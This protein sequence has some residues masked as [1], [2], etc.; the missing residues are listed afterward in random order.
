MHR[1]YVGIKPITFECRPVCAFG[2]II[3]KVNVPYYV[4]AVN[5]LEAFFILIY[6]KINNVYIKLV[7]YK[8]KALAIH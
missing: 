3:H 1:N 7:L 8:S 2:L 5:H 6:N 4:F